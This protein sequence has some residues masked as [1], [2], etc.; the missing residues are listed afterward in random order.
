MLSLQATRKR[1]LSGR[2][3]CN[4][5]SSP[6]SSM[7]SGKTENRKTEFA[8]ERE[9]THI[10]FFVTKTLF[11]IFDFLRDYHCYCRLYVQRE[12]EREG[13]KSLN[14][15]RTYNRIQRRRRKKK[16]TSKRGLHSKCTVDSTSWANAHN[17]VSEH[18]H[19]LLEP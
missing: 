2:K 5:I 12:G 7:N 11:L 9:K 17:Q 4:S 19:H 16:P 18:L 6:R 1:D 13:S 14:T 8:K 10:F 15:L 3:S